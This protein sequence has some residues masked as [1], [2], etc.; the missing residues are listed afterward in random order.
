M[1]NFNLHGFFKKQYLTEG[2][3]TT[4]PYDLQD[5]PDIKIFA[6]TLSKMLNV[7]VEQ[8]LGSGRYNGRGGYY[9]KMPRQIMYWDRDQDKIKAEA[10]FDKI[11]KLTK[12]YE[13][14]LND[15]RYVCSRG[16]Q[17]LL[18]VMRY[19]KCHC[20][21][22]TIQYNFPRFR[23]MYISY[24]GGKNTKD[25]WQQFLT[26]TQNQGCDRVTG[27][28]VT[29]SVAKLWAKMYGFERKYITVELKLN[30]EQE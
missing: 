19:D 26:W 14:E 13:F 18:M 22:T 29:E 17:Q 10:I 6:D 30:K 25:G 4:R 11:N 5:H 2:D 9:I 21:L 1:D 3:I 15:L 16:E 8:R 24:I 27:S 12:E 20:A 7:N 23:T 28:A